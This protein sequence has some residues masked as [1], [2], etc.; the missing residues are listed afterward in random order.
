MSQCVDGS[1]LLQYN[2]GNSQSIFSLFFWADSKGSQD[3]SNQD[4]IRREHA[5]INR[6]NV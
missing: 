3:N 5:Y 4:S 1:C 2:C 6:C